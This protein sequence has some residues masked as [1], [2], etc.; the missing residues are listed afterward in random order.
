MQAL[1]PLVILVVTIWVAVDASRL[2]AKR[3]ALGG[4]MLDM[5]PVGWFFACLLLW[6]IT[7]PCYLVARPKLVR[8]AKA[9]A[10]HQEV[11][12]PVHPQY[13]A[14]VNAQTGPQRISAGGFAHTPY[15]PAGW[16]TSPDGLEASWWDGANWSDRES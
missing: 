7:F 4:G 8:R 16:Y 11:G 13:S 3:G 10:S 1:V 2:G 12:A 9:L 15:S 5:G 6:I 14:A